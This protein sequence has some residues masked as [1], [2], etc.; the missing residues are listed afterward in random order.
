MDFSLTSNVTCCPLSGLLSGELLSLQCSFRFHLELSSPAPS[1]LLVWLWHTVSWTITY[2]EK[3]LLIK[4]N[5]TLFLPC[6]HEYFPEFLQ[7]KFSNSHSPSSV[8]V[9]PVRKM[10][11]TQ[12]LVTAPQSWLLRE[13]QAHFPLACV[14]LLRCAAGSQTF[15]Q[16]RT[17]MTEAIHV[18][19]RV[20]HPKCYFL[21][22]LSHISE[23]IRS[24]IL[25]CLFLSPS[26]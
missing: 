6:W 25:L 18:V 23:N 10:D 11:P 22:G 15:T 8:T 2:C 5:L 9:T 7:W 12:A 16:A 26:S 1:P 3:A 20:W 21:Q 19:M 4:C 13:L 17:V 14:A 24:K